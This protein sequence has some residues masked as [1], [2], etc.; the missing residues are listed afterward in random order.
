MALQVV[1]L[2]LEL[3]NLKLQYQRRSK[4]NFNDVQHSIRQYVSVEG[5]DLFQELHC[6][7]L[8]SNVTRAQG[9]ANRKFNN[10]WEYLM[11]LSNA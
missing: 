8:A 6:K 2:D 5:N 9:L 4:V 1:K 7:S 3:N 11:A 10:L